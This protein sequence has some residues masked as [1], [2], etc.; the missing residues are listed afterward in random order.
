M[1]LLV[2]DSLPLAEFAA[3]HLNHVLDSLGQ[4]R[5]LAAGGLSTFN[6]QLPKNLAARESWGLVT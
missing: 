5:A 6:S 1:A 4:S 3:Q 2:E